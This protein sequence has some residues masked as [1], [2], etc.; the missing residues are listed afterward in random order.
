MFAPFYRAVVVVGHLR[1]TTGVVAGSAGLER[2][3]QHVAHVLKPLPEELGDRA[4]LHTAGRQVADLGAR[5]L[6]LGQLRR[7]VREGLRGRTGLEGGVPL[8]AGLDDS[9]LVGGLGLVGL[10]HV[11]SPVCWPLFILH[12]NYIVVQWGESTVKTLVLEGVYDGPQKS[13]LGRQLLE[14]VQGQ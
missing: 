2:R 3:H 14:S 11:G 1:P 7:V 12:L 6:A 10:G 13:R 9:L 8:R 5:G 4:V